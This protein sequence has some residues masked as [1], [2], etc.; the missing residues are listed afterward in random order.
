MSKSAK[1]RA[2]EQFAAT[3]KKDRQ[4]LKEKESAQQVR[5]DHQAKLRGL[6]LAK[7]AADRAA[8]A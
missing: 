7:E 8:D 6:R 2:E 1:S 5:A 3:Q 4:A